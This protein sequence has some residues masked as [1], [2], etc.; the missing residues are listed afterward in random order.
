VRTDISCTLFLSDPDEYVGGELTVEDTYGTR[1]V[2]LPAG[3]MVVYPGTSLHRVTPVTEG[4][5]FASIF[6]V[7]SFVRSDAQR[8]IWFLQKGSNSLRDVYNMIKIFLRDAK[9]NNF[10]IIFYQEYLEVRL[11]QIYRGYISHAT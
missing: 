4:A 11:A 10:L 1:G 6:W 7:Q 8:S 3:Q 5:R 9:C 2:K